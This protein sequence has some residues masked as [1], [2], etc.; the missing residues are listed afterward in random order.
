MATRPFQIRLMLYIEA[1]FITLIGIGLGCILAFVLLNYWI[2]NGLDLSAFS[3]SLSAMGV[4]TV[5][6]PSLNWDQVR[7]GFLMIFAMVLLSVLYPAFK[8]SRFEPVDA[9]NYV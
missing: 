7:T 4:D 6:Y 2:Q 3:E 5:I 8:A 9:I 1:L